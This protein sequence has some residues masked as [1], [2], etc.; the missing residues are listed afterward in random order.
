MAIPH[1][2]LTVWFTGLSGSGKTTLSRE[3]YLRLSEEGYR[4]DL[5]DGDEVRLFLSKDLGFSKADRDEN[6]RRIGYVAELLTRNGVITLVS[7]ISPY[8]AA[9]DAVRARTPN[10]LEVFVN[11]PIEECER[12]DVK[13]LYKRARAGEIK[14]FTGI[15]DPYEEP[16][17]AEVDCR[18]DREAVEESA[19]S[20]LRRRWRARW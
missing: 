4:V 3:V 17:S 8:R 10:F 18:T 5:L 19:P 14:A 12:R 20:G 6:V 13:G 9:R 7:A 15:S 11:A 2:G 1:A 16:L